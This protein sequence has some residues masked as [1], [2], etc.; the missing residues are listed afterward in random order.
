[1]HA[2]NKRC[3]RSGMAERRPLQSCPPNI[4]FIFQQHFQNFRSIGTRDSR[5][6]GPCSPLEDKPF[7]GE[8]A[9]TNSALRAC[10]SFGVA[11]EGLLGSQL[12]L[13]VQ[14][15]RIWHESTTTTP[16]RTL[17]MSV[18][19]Q[20]AN[21]LQQFRSA[22]RPSRQRLYVEAYTWVASND[23]CWPYSFLNLCDALRLSP[24]CVRAELLSNALSDRSLQFRGAA[25]RVS[26]ALRV[27]S[28][29]SLPSKRFS[30][31]AYARENQ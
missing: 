16:E 17:A 12:T 20:A 4:R 23:R 19:C 13:P 6:Q 27:G 10:M 1:M 15:Q 25:G 3:F 30:K 22:R 14:F 11:L 18:L 24:E 5:G 28:L 21:D 31:S 26:R 29:R 9:G 8:C 2:R 7:W